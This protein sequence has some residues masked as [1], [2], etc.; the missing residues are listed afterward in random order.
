MGFG[1]QVLGIDGLAK[2]ELLPVVERRCRAA[3]LSVR[4][5]SWQS[6]LA[7]AVAGGRIGEYPYNELERLWL[8]LF[9]VFF[10]DATVAGRPVETP[11]S[12][13]KLHESG[14]VEHLKRSGITGMRPV[15]PLATGW[16][17]MAGHSLLHHSVVRPLIDEGHVVIQDSLG[18]KNVL[19]SLFMAEFSAPGHAPA[20]TAVRDHVKDYFG[21]A[22]A[23]RVG[24]YLR[25]DPARVLAAKNARTIGVFDTYHAFG[26]DPGQTFLDLQTDCARE[27]ENFART[28]GWTIVDAHDAAEATGSASEK[29]TDTILATAA[30]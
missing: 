7:A 23:P 19:K 3:G 10:A 21:R 29:V 16:L 17:E 12:F 24:I 4:R 30:R 18:I 11:R 6:E 5:V 15:S 22:L 9:P 14:L 8:E 27:Y 25:E 1:V 2:R 28:H 13:A 20:L 26:G